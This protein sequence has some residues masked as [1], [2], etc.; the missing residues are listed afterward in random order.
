[1]IQMRKHFYRG[2]TE[3]FDMMGTKSANGMDEKMIY[4]VLLVESKELNV[5]VYITFSFTL[6]RMNSNPTSEIV[7]GNACQER[8]MNHA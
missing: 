7:L 5:K 4:I 6:L 2:N 8:K 3:L 1:M